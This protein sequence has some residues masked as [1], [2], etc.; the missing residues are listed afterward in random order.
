MARTLEE[1]KSAALAEYGGDEETIDDPRQLSEEELERIEY[2]DEFHRAKHSF[3]VELGCRIAAGPKV[4]MF[5]TT[6]Y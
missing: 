5:A 3:K 4:E 6:E 1:A 2:F